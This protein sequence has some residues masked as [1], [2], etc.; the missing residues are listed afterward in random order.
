MSRLLVNILTRIALAAFYIMTNRPK[1]KS[2]VFGIAALLAAE[3]TGRALTVEFLQAAIDP[4]T[5][6]LLS[7]LACRNLDHIVHLD[8]SVTWPETSLAVETDGYR[9]LIFWNES[10]EFLFPKGAYAVRHGS[11]AV[12]GYFIA[13][14]GGVH[15][16]IVS[17]FL[18]KADDPGVKRTPGM[19]EKKAEGSACR[20]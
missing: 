12:K 1:W 9:R 7:G 16:G 8:L 2:A 13:R 17:N 3:N 15:Q 4:H 6:G 14:A 20:N 19:V 11:Y 18:E 10:D 5:A